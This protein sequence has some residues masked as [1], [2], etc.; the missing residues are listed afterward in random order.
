MIKS[1]IDTFS[2]P[3]GEVQRTQTIHL[4]RWEEL[5][6]FK[7]FFCKEAFLHIC[8]LYKKHI[9]PA[10]PFAFPRMILFTVPE[11]YRY[12]L[13]EAA[14]VLR[15]GVKI[16][17]KGEPLFE[18]EYAKEVYEELE[19]KELITVIC[20]NRKN[21]KVLPVGRSMGF[22]TECR[23]EAALKVNSSFFTMDCFDINSEYDAIG[24][25]L[26]LM[27]KDGEVLNP[28]AFNREALLVKYSGEVLVEK[29]GLKDVS[30]KIGNR[31][32]KINENAK[33]YERPQYIKTPVINKGYIGIVVIGN[34]VCNVVG[35]GKVNVPSSGFVL[36]VKKFDVSRGDEVTYS[37]FENYKF[38]I[39][40]GNSVIKDGEKTLRFESD[41]FNIRNLFR[42]KRAYPPSLYPLKYN[43]ARAPRIVLG[44]DACG[45]P[46]VMWVE[47]AGKGSYK[48]GDYSAGASLSELAGIAEKEG[49]LNAVNLDGG[50]SAQILLDNKRELF[51]SDRDE[52][53]KESERAIPVGL[54]VRY[55]E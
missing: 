52:E 23:T 22:M 33:V 54:M 36:K 37:G 7:P 9:V 5:D 11:E 40:V 28:P 44:A 48:I 13:L 12:S 27:V 38:C 42:F 29:I 15:D 53:N 30:V 31:T 4:E 26:G 21:T 20:G 34:K 32:F 25:P 8:L 18:S 2:Y 45:M 55:N 51:I 35:S 24:T 46:M 17:A 49:F 19:A 41:F 47:G 14:D 39:Q 6:F 43:T 50:G 3:N 10:A 16:N 1:S